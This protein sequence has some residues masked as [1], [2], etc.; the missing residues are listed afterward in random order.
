MVS[1]GLWASLVPRATV[2]TYKTGELSN[3]VLVAWPGWGVQQNLG[4]LTGTVGRINVWVSSEPEAEPRLTLAASLLDADSGEILRQTTIDVTPSYIPVARMLSFPAYTIS[5][6]QRLILQLQ[7]AKHEEYPVIFRLSYP[8]RDIETVRLNGVPDSGAGPLAFEQIKAG[9]GLRFAIEREAPERIRF[10]LAILFSVTALLAHPRAI[11][12]VRNSRVWSKTRNVW[13]GIVRLGNPDWLL[14]SNNR[15]TAMS[16]VSS[17]PW[18]P[19][20]L[21]VIPILHFLANNHLSFAFHEYLLPAGIAIMVISVLAIGSWTLFKDW[22]RSAA[23][24]A[25]V[26]AL[27]FAYGHVDTALDRRLDERVLFALTAMLAALVVVAIARQP[28]RVAACTPG[29][30]AVAAVLLMFSS[31]GLMAGLAERQEPIGAGEPLASDA[32]LQH[33]PELQ[34]PSDSQERPDIFYIILD[35]YSRQDALGELDNSDFLRQLERRGFYVARE[36]TSNYN[37]S[38]RS[39]TSSLNMSYLEALDYRSP[40]SN[41]MAEASLVAAGRNNALAIILRRLGYTYE[42]LG[43]GY[44]LTDEASL[45]DVSL[46]FTPDGVLVRDE[47]GGSSD[48]RVSQG[49]LRALLQITAL[50]P[51]MDD[52]FLRDRSKP[53]DWWSPQRA[54]RMFG[55]LT[56]GKQ[57]TISG[58]TFVFAHIVKTHWPAT[59]DRFGN[60]VSGES[61]YD[62]FDDNHDPGVPDAYSGKLLYVN[63]IVL[64]MVDGILDNSRSDPIIVIAADHGHRRG[65]DRHKV[66]A[67]FR[68]PAGGIDGLY[69]SISSVNHFRYILDYYFGLG[70]GLLDDVIVRDS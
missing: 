55:V 43:S 41:P 56:H 4:R 2:A 35:S 40:A 16:R 57:V 9:S 20:P 68:L 26:S 3:D 25:A 45:A 58:P 53:F 37:D 48:L 18:Y 60:Q 52:R 63:S 15:A 32:F 69:P 27:F 11:A 8:H 42:H 17:S 5:V 47:E 34:W 49:F 33:L 46:E 7:V 12:G 67:A 30:N 39:I 24:A 13:A 50:Q 44:R 6:D 66:L 51:I 21:A 23:I 28:K 1:L 38:I 54:L 14:E 29:L 62:A 70:L 61:E 64:D 19:W 65:L 22:H 10:V 31:V 59:F 36:A